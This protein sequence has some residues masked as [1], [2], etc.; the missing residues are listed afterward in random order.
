MPPCQAAGGP[1]RPGGDLTKPPSMADNG[2]MVKILVVEDNASMREMLASIIAD[3]G[4]AVDAAADVA[5][6]LS[7]LKRNDYALVISDLQLP[8]LDGLSF[9]KKARDPQLP[10]IILT[11]FGSI[12]K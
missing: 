5:S 12:E 4:Y 10:F 3:R 9:M 8:D 6:A 11:A 7:L 2:A 1:R